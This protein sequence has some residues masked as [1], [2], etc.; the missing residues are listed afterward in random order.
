[1]T[2]GKEVDQSELIKVL[3]G[4]DP[5]KSLSNSCL[6][7]IDRRAMGPNETYLDPWGMPYFIA[8]DT[9]G[10]GNCTTERWGILK[11]KGPFVWS[12][13]GGP[14]ASWQSNVVHARY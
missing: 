2:F 12:E 1:M 9:D 7:V 5:V 4:L 6:L 10:D 8:F 11:G 14:I 13:G 3:L